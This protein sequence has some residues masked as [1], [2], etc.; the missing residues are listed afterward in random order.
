MLMLL[1]RTALATVAPALGVSEVVTSDL[2]RLLST[3]VASIA[4]VYAAVYAN[5]A[6]E[7]RRP[8]RR[9]R[10]D[11]ALEREVAELRARLEQHEQGS[12]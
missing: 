4:S 11:A 10:R 2:L 6:R 9:R 12:A 5:R 3:L 8:L 7:R 1:Q